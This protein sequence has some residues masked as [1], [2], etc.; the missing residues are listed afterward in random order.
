MSKNQDR[1]NQ[2]VSLLLAEIKS[3]WFGAYAI[4]AHKVR[5]ELETLEKFAYEMASTIASLE[6]ES[7]AQKLVIEKLNQKEQQK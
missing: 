2:D 6:G 4:Q 7:G 5:E 1:E 3:K